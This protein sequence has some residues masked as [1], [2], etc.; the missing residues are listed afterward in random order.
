MGWCE[1]W[2]TRIVQKAPIYSGKLTGEKCLGI[3]GEN[4]FSSLLY[5]D[6]KT[7]T[8]FRQH[9]ASPHCAAEI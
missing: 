9:G 2:S 4:G 7:S 6:K 3:L 8:L 1:T 5:T